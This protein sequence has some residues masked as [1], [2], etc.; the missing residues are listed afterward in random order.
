MSK[1]SIIAVLLL[2]F[3]GSIICFGADNEAQVLY[4]KGLAALEKKEIKVAINLFSEAI[5]TDARYMDAYAKRAAAYAANGDLKSAAK[6]YTRAIELSQPAPDAEL[7]HQLALCYGQLGQLSD[8]LQ[9]FDLAIKIGPAK[10][11]YY[12][13][14]AITNNL[15]KDSFH[16]IED[17][18]RAI[19]MDSNYVDSYYARG[20]VYGERAEYKLALQDF[21]FVVSARPKD[22]RA[23]YWRGKIQFL[24]GNKT[25]A[26]KEYA[27]AV[28]LAGVELPIYSK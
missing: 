28:K 1:K 15:N 7:Y 17:L 27:Q 21:D 12:Y 26:N 8:A 19:E 9:N 24:Q 25:A 3:S 6:D 23:Y 14:R 5:K 13:D 10:P 20:I 22:Y 18:N 2:V 11:V 4:Q 16:A